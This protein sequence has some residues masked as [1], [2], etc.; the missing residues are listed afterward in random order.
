MFYRIGSCKWKGINS[1]KSPPLGMG[2]APTPN[3]RPPATLELA[4]MIDHLEVVQSS[5]QDCE[6]YLDTCN[7]L[8]EWRKTFPLSQ[9]NMQQVKDKSIDAER[10]A[11][12]FGER[13]SQEEIQKMWANRYKGLTYQRRK[14]NTRQGDQQDPVK[15]PKKDTQPVDQV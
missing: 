4:N 3:Q 13:P 6:N 8:Y 7:K 9:E 10:A 14:G 15:F 11:R 2:I 5:A 12:I 1:I